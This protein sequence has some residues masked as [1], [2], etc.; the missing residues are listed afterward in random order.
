MAEFVMPSLGAD[1]ES[2]TMVEWMVAPGATVKRGD[3]VA[4][5]E[6]AKGIID[7][8]IFDD[9][10]IEQLLAEPG[11]QVAVGGVLATYKPSRAGLDVAP[12]PQAAEV[13]VV[14]ERADQSGPGAPAAAAAAAE[15]AAR[16][17]ISPSARRRAREL[18]LDEQLLATLT[19]SGPKG[20]ITTDDVERAHATARPSAVKSVAPD[21]GAAQAPAVA[22]AR[23]VPTAKARFAASS[24]MQAVIA[25]AM[26]RSKR[27]IPHYYLGTTIDMTR[28]FAWLEQWNTSHDVTERVLY[29]AL[30]IKAVA[31]AL[32]HS[33]DLN[34]FCRDGRHV[35]SDSIHVGFAIRLIR[36]GLV[37]PAIADANL[38]SLP[39]VMNELRD[40]VRRARSGHLRNAEL[41]GGTIT[42]S[43]LGEDSVET[44]YPVI[45]P[46]QVAI[47]GFGSP[48]LRPWC[49]DG[50]LVAAKL[51]Q[52]TLSGDH[53][54]SD[55][56]RGAAFLA[57]VDHAL[58]QPEELLYER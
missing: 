25:Q 49:V 10:V 21:T 34:G 43:S 30:L 17:R 44:L 42:I 23:E 6:T 8:E 19:G 48:L 53:R 36:G 11:Q 26:T 38:K 28:A 47:V 14:G 40:L 33:P 58:Q 55:G 54:V 57:A 37:A 13:P 56:H 9:G 16:P 12:R 35:A 41:T 20:A 46:P 3:V 52:A 22:P 39:A 50:E 27:E 5:V 15:L 51:I 32:E 31:V 18:G 2:A 45:N 7:I 1:M 29:A 24:D 4:A